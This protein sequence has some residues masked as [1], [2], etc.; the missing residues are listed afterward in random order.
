MGMLVLL[1]AVVALLLP[2]A[3]QPRET[4][5]DQPPA[6][7][8]HVR[9]G[10]DAPC[11]GFPNRI[12]SPEGRHRGL[13]GTIHGDALLGLA[14]GPGVLAR[15]GAHRRR[16]A[17][18]LLSRRH[19]I[20]CHHLS[21]QGRPGAVGRHDGR[22]HA[23]GPCDDTA[24]GVAA[25]RQDGRC[26]CRRHAAEHPLGG[27]TAHRAGTDRQAPLASADRPMHGLPPCPIIDHHLPDRDDHHRCQ[28]L[29]ACSRADS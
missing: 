21:G 23:A 17:R 29:E 2:E 15:R 5:C 19:G 4:D 10:N 11:R 27:D 12:Q 13:H 26:R 28:C 20:E 22:L 16:R 3:L 24:A 7:R 1:C 18:G 6:G 25:G 8:H 14:A 9:H